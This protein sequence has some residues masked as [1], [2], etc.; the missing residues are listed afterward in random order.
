[1]KVQE[2]L[3]HKDFQR[4]V[5]FHGHIC[6]GLA[7]GFQA[8][9]ILMERLGV[10]AAPDE[11][12][13]ATVETDACSV[14][15][16]QVLAKCTF[17]KGNLKFLDYGKHA[18]SLTDRKQGKTIRVCLR[19]DALPNHS[20]HLSLFEKVH[21]GHATAEE[22]RLFKQ[23]REERLNNILSADP[24]SLFTIEEISAEIPPQ[25]RITESE[26]CE[27]CGEPT[28]SNHLQE[29][30]GQKVCIPCALKIS[31]GGD[32][33]KKPKSSNHPHPKSKQK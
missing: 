32:N 23:L 1:M 13:V 5:D 16:I 24:E 19:P 6:P 8:A 2:I 33:R 29:K 25:A 26:V 17:G 14:D 21:K 28:M 30:G 20:Q 22:I 3:S 15:A 10:E 12:L 27:R 7:I 18:F 11:E 31:K 4:C 9:R